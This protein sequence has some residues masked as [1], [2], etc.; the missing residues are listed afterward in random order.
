MAINK[1]ISS[2]SPST[3]S[4]CRMFLKQCEENN[5]PVAVIETT[6]DDITQMLYY[7]Q[8]RLDVKNNKQIATEYNALR[9]KYGLWEDAIN[10]AL[11]KPITWSLNSNHAKGKA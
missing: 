6:R 1:D 3:A 9:K 2:L 11:F 4:K 10:D 7:M 8:G 5:L